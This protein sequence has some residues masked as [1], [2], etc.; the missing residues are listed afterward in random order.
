MANPA[1]DSAVASEI[2]PAPWTGSPR[3]TAAQVSPEARTPDDVPDTTPYAAPHSTP[4]TTP[5]PASRTSRIPTGL[6]VRQVL[7]VPSLAGARIVAGHAGADR[8]VE[9]INVMEVPDILP[10]VKPNELLL[11]TGFPLRHARGPLSYL[12]TRLDRAGLAALAIKP[13]RSLGALPAD[14]LP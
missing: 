11:T 4:Y 7:T 14:L 8:I 5:I 6:T 13:H 1:N 10:W 12:A 9:R 2:S 3:E